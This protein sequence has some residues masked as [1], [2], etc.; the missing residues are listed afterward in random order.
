MFCVKMQTLMLLL[1]QV[2]L[3]LHKLRI[4]LA[5]VVWKITHTEDTLGTS[6]L[7][8]LEQ[9]EDTLGTSFL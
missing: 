3:N 9:T 6:C 5:Q 2:V 4:H 8:K 7:C 1:V